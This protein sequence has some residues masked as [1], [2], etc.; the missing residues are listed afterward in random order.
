MQANCQ[1]CGKPYR[2]DTTHITGASAWFNCKACGE[3][4]V[5]HKPTPSANNGNYKPSK[6]A[7]PQHAKPSQQVSIEETISGARH[8]AASTMTK[9][10]AVLGLRAKMLLLFLVIPLTLMGFASMVY[11][12]ELKGLATL[13]TQESTRFVTDLAENIIREKAHSVA[14]QVKL[15]LDSHPG[16]SGP[17]FNSHPELVKLGLQP[18]GKTGYTALL[19]IAN[20]R[21]E[22]PLWIHPNAKLIGVDLAKTEKVLG[23]R[24][25]QFWAIVHETKNNPETHG[26]YLWQDADGALREK[27]M[28]I[29]RVQGTPYAIASTT[30][31]DEF[32]QPVHDLELKA[33][34]IT[35]QARQF[36]ILALSITLALVGAIV[37]A[38]GMRLTGQVRSLTDQA[39]RISAGDLGS[40]VEVR[41]KDE[42]GEL[43]QAIARM[44]TS[45]QL[46]IERLRRRG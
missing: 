6:A 35:D 21:D 12:K 40:K 29:T 22:V 28:V 9:K 13:I 43:A 27:F 5:V 16:L 7:A 37:I 24:F 2:I 3:R 33:G 46:S 34:A 17:D 41:S 11:V 25:P 19:Q 45:I 23:D 14:A 26:Y 44:Q 30:Y 4:I 18:V 20:E 8:A 38:Y 42:I 36:A 15:Y 1:Q 10:R 39:N 31:L 32:T